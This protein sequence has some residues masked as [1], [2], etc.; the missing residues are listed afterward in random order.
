VPS[1]R[2]Q[3]IGLTTKSL[4]AAPPI[5][6]TIADKLSA[7]I[8]GGRKVNYISIMCHEGGT[9]HISWHNHR[10]DLGHDT[11]VMIVSAG[12]ERKFSVRP[13]GQPKKAQ[14]I[15]AK[16]GS[17][18]LMPS[19]F[20]ETHEHAVLDQKD[21]TGIRWAINAKCMD[22][23][24]CGPRVFCCKA[25]HK[26]PADAVYVGCR[27]IRGQAREGSIF[28]NALDPLKVRNKKSNPWRATTEEAF[29]AYAL[30]R[31]KDPSFRQQVEA[32]RGKHLLCW[33]LQDGPKRAKFCHAR[34][35]LD[36]INRRP[37]I[38]YEQRSPEEQ[39]VWELNHPDVPCPPRRV[40]ANQRDLDDAVQRAAESDLETGLGSW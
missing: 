18:I 27:T 32:L 14:H 10:E 35:W 1:T 20:N 13:K 16:R 24:Y 15:I 33:C 26:P 8:G 36:L 29:R 11:P 39:A 31:L 9:D 2:A 21:C 34:V 19:S 6:R 37:S 12:A 25:G 40:R 7:K 30:D 28:G 3:Q 17:L 4:S 38:V 22:D 23:V 5:I